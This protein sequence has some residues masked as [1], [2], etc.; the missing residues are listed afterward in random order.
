[1]TR[2]NIEH[3]IPATFTQLAACV[4]VAKLL[5]YSQF[6]SGHGKQH[7]SPAVNSEQNLP[8]T[9]P[10]VLGYK[11]SWR[12]GVGHSFTPAVEVFVVMLLYRTLIK[13]LIK[14]VSRWRCRSTST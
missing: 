9:N 4:M 14:G 6:V 10:P 7:D 2:R 13:M 12:N 1:V 5:G 11:D 8:A 3:I